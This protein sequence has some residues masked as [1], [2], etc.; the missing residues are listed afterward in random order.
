MGK[1]PSWVLWTKREAMKPQTSLVDVKKEKK[2]CL[3]A[4]SPPQLLPPAPSE[5][6]ASWSLGHKHRAHC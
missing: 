6:G 5:L 4:A 2:E 3:G 1:A